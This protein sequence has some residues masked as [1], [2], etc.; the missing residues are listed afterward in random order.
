VKGFEEFD[1]R[2]DNLFNAPKEQVLPVDKELPENMPIHQDT[3]PI[4][5]DK[6]GMF[7]HYLVIIH[8]SKLVVTEYTNNN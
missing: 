3:P 1:G 2:L 4:L 5:S 7:H 8:I 6:S